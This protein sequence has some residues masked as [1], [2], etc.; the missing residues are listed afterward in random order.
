MRKG[1]VYLK[2]ANASRGATP[3]RKIYLVAHNVEK[4]KAWRLDWFDEPS[5][6]RALG[7]SV[8]AARLS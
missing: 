6:F 2:A 1:S 8:R 5:E 7:S 4:A 3:A